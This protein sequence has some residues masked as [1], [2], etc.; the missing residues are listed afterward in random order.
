MLSPPVVAEGINQWLRLFAVLN[1]S[2]FCCKTVMNFLSSWRIYF[3]RSLELTH[4]IYEQG[5]FLGNCYSP[6]GA[7]RSLDSFRKPAML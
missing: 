1:A 4:G 7:T 6:C 5:M 2:K 3:S